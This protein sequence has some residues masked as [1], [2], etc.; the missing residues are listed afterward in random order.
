MEE[1][2]IL[3]DQSLLKLMCCLV[4]MVLL[5]FTRGETQAIVVAT[6]G[7]SRDAQRIEAIEG[8]GTDNFMLQLQF[9][10]HIVLVR[11]A[12]LWDLREEKLD[13]VI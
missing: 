3:L 6:L 1:I 11:L 8:Q 7:S 2:L 12:C 4:L 9:S 13:M 5:I 10:W